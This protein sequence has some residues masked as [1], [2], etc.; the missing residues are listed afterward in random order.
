MNNLNKRAI[1]PLSG[2]FDSFSPDSNGFL[3]NVRSGG[4]KRDMNILR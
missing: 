3:S 2:E 1:N 4:L